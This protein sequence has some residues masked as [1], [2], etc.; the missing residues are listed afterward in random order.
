MPNDY[1]GPIAVYNIAGFFAIF[2]TSVPVMRIAT[3]FVG[4]LGVLATYLLFRR[5]FGRPAAV[6]TSL[7][8]ATDLTYVLAMRHD[9]GATSMGLLIRM[10]VLYFFLSWWSN[11]ERVRFL[12]LSSLVLGVALTY[13]FDYLSFVVSAVA[14][15]ILFYGLWLRPRARVREL[16]IASAGFV[17]GAFPI[18]LYNILTGGRTFKEGRT[19]AAGKGAALLPTSLEQIGPFMRALPDKIVSQTNH[20]LSLTDGTYV[21]NWIFGGGFERSLPY[22]VAL[23][24]MAVKIAVP[25][26]VVLMFVPRF[27]R[28]RRPLGFIIA[29]FLLTL[30]FLAA[31][32]IASGPHHILSLY[33]LPHLLV[34]IVLAGVWE[35]GRDRPWWLSWAVRAIPAA[36]LALLIGSNLVL[37]QRFHERLITEGANGYWSEAIYDLSDAM[38]T[39]YQGK[40][41]VLL[42]WGLEQPLVILGKNQFKLNIPL[43][44]MLAEPNSDAWLTEL[45]RDPNNLFAIRSEKFAWNADIHKR[46]QDA[47]LKERPTVQ[48]EKFF[49][50]NGE[51]AF[52]V[53]RFTVASP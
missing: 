23:M 48:E 30:L 45:I 8:V 19:I 4:L 13:R 9:W 7:L 12:F 46:F 26:L 39:R 27:R 34:G 32:P 51:H 16:V 37:A 22:G 43:W 17:I 42:D 11:R 47:Y 28:W 29:V 49:Q 53:L 50:K 5:E 21:P 52:S 6:I 15:I 36:A 1:I 24:P 14:G 44:R 40:T 20:L 2:G 41:V 25:L 3:S 35:L 38:K 31:T 33:P 18:L 10:L